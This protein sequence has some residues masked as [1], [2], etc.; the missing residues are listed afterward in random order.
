MNCRLF[1][2]SIA[3]KADMETFKR[4]ATVA[5]DNTYHYMAQ[6]SIRLTDYTDPWVETVTVFFKKF[7]PSVINAKKQF[8][9]WMFYL[10][11]L[12]YRLLIH[13]Q[14]YFPIIAINAV[15]STCICL[16]LVDLLKTQDNHE[17]RG[18]ILICW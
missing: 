7:I 11:K 10:A 6:A 15:V 1:I 17:Q 8:S 18:R 2:Y 16:P 13:R 5:M 12:A 3:E 9:W 14:P 4:C